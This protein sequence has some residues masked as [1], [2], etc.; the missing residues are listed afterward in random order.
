MIFWDAASNTV[1]STAAL[2][3]SEALTILGWAFRTDSK[4]ETQI[5]RC[6]AA[7]TEIGRLRARSATRVC[8]EVGRIAV[9]TTGGINGGQ[10]NF[11]LCDDSQAFSVYEQKRRV[12]RGTPTASRGLP[13]GPV[14]DVLDR[15]CPL[16]GGGRQQGL[17]AAG[18][19]VD[20]A[21]L[22]TLQQLAR[23]R[24]LLQELTPATPEAHR[25]TQTL[26]LQTLERSS[27]YNKS[28]PLKRMLP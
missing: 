7:E 13:S 9:L 23:Q 15:L 21:A 20:H 28:H 2:C 10:S 24:A 6:S 19:H 17:R 18:G 14:D 8:C 26:Q 3:D 22:R 5:D 25:R 11:R 16:G 27:N 4:A 1:S 12:S